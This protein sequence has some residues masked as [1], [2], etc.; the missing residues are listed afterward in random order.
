MF[1]QNN[2]IMETLLKDNFT[3]ES[4]D[5]KNANTPVRVLT[6][7]SIIGD[8]VYN[9]ENKKLGT[10]K[11]VM[12]DIFAGK[13]DYVVI[14]FGGFLGLGEK[15]FA[16]PIKLLRL[17]SDR[18]AFIMDLKKEVLSQA[19]GFDKNHWPETNWHDIEPTAAY[20][21]GF[22]GQNVGQEY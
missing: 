19:P 7:S 5:G 16:V 15:Y 12:I 9:K 10:I 4:R 2:T 18:K 11:D 6:A 21:G 17:D 13:V 1:N 3:G 14:E 8:K 22:M 20:W